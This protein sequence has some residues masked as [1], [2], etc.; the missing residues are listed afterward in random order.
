MANHQDAGREGATRRYQML[1]VWRGVV[2]LLVVLEHVGVVLWVG[3]GDAPGVQGWFQRAVV[4][5]LSLN[6]G[7]PLFF[8]MSGYCVASCVESSRRKGH[9]PLMFLYRRFWRIFPTYWAALLVF[10]V[11]VLALDLAGLDRLHCS[12]LSLQIDSPKSLTWGQWL[13]NLTLTETWRRTAFGGASSAVYTRVAWSLCYQ[14][15]FYAICGLVLWLAPAKVSKTLAWTTLGI[16]AYRTFAADAG[17]LHTLDGV[18]VV[19]WHVFAAGLA[20][21]W[22]LNAASTAPV[23]T[24]RAVDAGLAALAVVGL[25]SG[26]VPTTAAGVFGLILI[27]LHRWDAASV[28]LAWLGPVRAC[29][30]RSYAIY[31]SHLPVV[32][33]G[34]VVLYDLGL[35]GLWARVLVVV[36]VVTAAALAFGWL[37]HHLVERHFMGAAPLP[38][39]AAAGRTTGRAAAT[40]A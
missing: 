3:A 9:S 22:R 40:T 34:N 25:V 16:V 27:G 1:D 11:L 20:V 32:M 4:A 12:D 13:G 29:G 5:V 19:H 38:K 39:F 15:Q 31:L 2:C 37:F 33:M 36:P 28:G 7:T 18:F 6:I 23:K 21:Y 26:S 14:E 24:R 8:V 30:R 17:F 35:N 10:A